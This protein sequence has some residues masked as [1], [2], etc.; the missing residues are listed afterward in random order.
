MRKNT[1]NMQRIVKI[2]LQ[3]HL[4][5]QGYK[6]VSK[7]LQKQSSNLQLLLKTPVTSEIPKWDWLSLKQDEEIK[8]HIFPKSTEQT[9][10]ARKKQKIR[11]SRT[12]KQMNSRSCVDGSTHLSLSHRLPLTHIPKVSTYLLDWWCLPGQCVHTYTLETLQDPRDG[13][14]KCIWL[15]LEEIARSFTPHHRLSVQVQNGGQ[16]GYWQLMSWVTHLTVVQRLP[17]MLRSQKI[18]NISLKLRMPWAYLCIKINKKY[19]KK[20]GNVCFCSWFVAV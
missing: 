2:S 19:C 11:H 7:A 6:Y 5:W 12:H 20:L 4:L 17:I 18:L 16:I 3:F 15:T 1:Q 10:K 9:R 13:S 8:I 14:R